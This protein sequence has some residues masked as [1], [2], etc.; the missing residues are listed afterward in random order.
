MA[1]AVTSS[2]CVIAI[3]SEIDTQLRQPLAFGRE[4]QP[5]FVGGPKMFRF[6][7]LLRSKLYGG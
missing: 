2:S 3:I 4:T 1:L 6:E 5:R 7:A